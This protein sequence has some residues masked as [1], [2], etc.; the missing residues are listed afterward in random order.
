MGMIHPLIRSG[1]VSSAAVLVDSFAPFLTR[2][3]PEESSDAIMVALVALQYCFRDPWSL[4]DWV[5]SCR[6]C[7]YVLNSVKDDLYNFC[8]RI[9]W[10]KENAISSLDLS[11]HV[12]LIEDASSTQ[13]I[14]ARVVNAT[15]WFNNET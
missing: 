9:Q 1:D 13:D 15:D 12:I 14:S 4:R 8:Q 3:L 11:L 6:C 5:Y 2:V 10:R 7:M